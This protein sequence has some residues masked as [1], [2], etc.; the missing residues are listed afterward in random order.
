MTKTLDDESN[1]CNDAPSPFDLIRL[2]H[3]KFGFYATMKELSPLRK[4]LFLTFRRDCIREELGELN[5]A[6]ETLDAD[7]AVDALVDLS[8]FAIGTLDLLGVDAEKAWRDVMRANLA[9]CPGEKRR[10]T[11]VD[12]FGFPELCKP[13]GWTAPCHSENLGDVAEAMWKAVS[14]EVASDRKKG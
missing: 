5:E 6:L 1:I 2:M 4:G 9:K 12:T 8:V 3:D 14:D 11:S 7:A 13:E 10:N